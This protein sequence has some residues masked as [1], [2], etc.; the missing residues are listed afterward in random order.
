MGRKLKIADR[1]TAG[2]KFWELYMFPV[3]NEKLLNWESLK[4]PVFV[5]FSVCFTVSKR[6]GT[7]SICSHMIRQVCCFWAA[8]EHW[9]SC[10]SFPHFSHFPHGSWAP[11]GSDIPGATSSFP[12]TLLSI[13]QEGKGENVTLVAQYICTGPGV[14]HNLLSCSPPLSSPSYP[15][16]GPKILQFH[17]GHDPMWHSL[18]ISA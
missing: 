18:T 3:E 9:W 15:S 4:S 7:H 10:S 11:A 17:G 2:Y 1:G 8:A 13:S 14:K 5:C 6:K 12:E 16:A